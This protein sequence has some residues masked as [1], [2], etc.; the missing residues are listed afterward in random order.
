MSSIFIFSYPSIV[1]K[2]LFWG[3]IFQMEVSMNLHVLKSPESVNYI[4]SD[5]SV[6]YKHK[7]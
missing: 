7:L 1:R 3:E 6:C 5:W 4:F 2:V